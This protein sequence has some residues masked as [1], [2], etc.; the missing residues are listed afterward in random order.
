MN[1]L[2]FSGRKQVPL[3]QQTEAAECGLACL[4]MVATYHGF[5]TDLPSLRRRFAVSAQ[6]MTLAQLMEFSGRMDLCARPLRVEL[7]ALNQLTL[8]A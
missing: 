2:R 8:P 5:D 1:P 4:A 6:G 3:L 7:E